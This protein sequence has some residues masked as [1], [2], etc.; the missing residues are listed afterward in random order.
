[1]M[2]L[3]IRKALELPLVLAVDALP[4]AERPGLKLAGVDRIT[5]KKFDHEKYASYIRATLDSYNERPV[6]LGATRD[7]V[8]G[9]FNVTV[10]ADARLSEDGLGRFVDLVK[11]AYPYGTDIVVE[12]RR[13]Q[14]N[15]REMSG[16]SIS[17]GRLAA[18]MTIFWSIG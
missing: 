10:F 11:S 6:T 2:A 3:R 18:G 13:L 17:N 7:A 4:P 8:K 9:R 14:V 5:G 15:R 16:T 12:G 1:M